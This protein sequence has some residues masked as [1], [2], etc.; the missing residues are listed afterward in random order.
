MEL[1]IGIYFQKELKQINDMRVIKSLLQ[2]FGYF[3]LIIAYLFLLLLKSVFYLAII[4]AIIYLLF[5][6]Y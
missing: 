3:T 4:I 1:L 6:S 5:R 2:G